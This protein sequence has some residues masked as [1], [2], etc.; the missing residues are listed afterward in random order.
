MVIMDLKMNHGNHFERIDL[1]ND[2][3]VKMEDIP[4][5]YLNRHKNVIQR[6]AVNR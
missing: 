6:K 3:K 4:V 2:G 1:I 5:N